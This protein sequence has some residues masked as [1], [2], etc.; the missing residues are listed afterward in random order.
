MDKLDFCNH[1]GAEL[2]W[3]TIDKHGR[4]SYC[5][6]RCQFLSWRW[7]WSWRISR[8]LKSPLA[9]KLN[10]H[11]GSKT[12]IGYD[13]C[14]RRVAFFCVK[15]GKKFKTVVLDDS[16][17]VGEVRDLLDERGVSSE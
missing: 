9:C 10:R 6:L 17:V 14:N 8:W 16:G 3:R 13:L 5:S 1:C 15:C 12:N 7:R 2:S 4:D 11:V